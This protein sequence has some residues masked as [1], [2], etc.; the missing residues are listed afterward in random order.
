ML[1]RALLPVVL[2]AGCAPAGAPS[3]GAPL[4]LFPMALVFV[5]PREMGEPIGALLADG[6]IVAKHGGVVARL[7]PDRVVSPDGTPK[8]VVTPGGDVVLDP[9]MPAMHFDGRGALVSP[10][11]ETIWVDDVGTPSW[12]AP[13]HGL[14][15]MD[16][17]RFTPFTPAARRT[18]EVL[19]I[20]LLEAAWSRPMT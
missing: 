20:V 9:H 1:L 12:V 2:V 8:I 13:G 10:R 5:G 16:G 19:L 4:P 18:A 15:P 11:G 14:P 6:T 7:L 3:S 17:V